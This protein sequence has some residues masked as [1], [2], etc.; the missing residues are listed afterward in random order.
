MKKFCLLVS[1]I[2]N[3]QFGN[4]FTYEGT[5]EECKEVIVKFLLNHLLLNIYIYPF[6]ESE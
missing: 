3:E 5:A 4:S 1:L 2:D 6:E